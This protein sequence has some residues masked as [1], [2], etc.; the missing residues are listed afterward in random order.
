MT[1][2]Q[3]VYGALLEDDHMDMA[4]EL[5]GDERKASCFIALRGQI[6]DRWLQKN[7]GVEVRE[8]GW[9]DAEEFRDIEE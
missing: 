8:V 1:I 4:L 3:E 7:A 2:V 5:L 6:R 9:A